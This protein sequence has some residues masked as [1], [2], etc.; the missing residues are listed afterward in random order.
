VYLHASHTETFGNVVTEAMASGLA[1]GAFDYAAAREFIVN[2][3]QG[4]TCPPGDEAAFIAQAERIARSPVLRHAL[5]TAARAR[6]ERLSWDAVVDGFVA[7]LTDAINE[8]PAPSPAA[9]AP[10][11]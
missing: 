2:G 6:A 1:V 8:S 4:L 10:P 7:D 3:Q 11:H 5:S 9:G